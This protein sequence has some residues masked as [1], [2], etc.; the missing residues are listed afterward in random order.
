MITLAQSALAKRKAGGSGMSPG[1]GHGGSRGHSG[2]SDGE[3]KACDSARGVNTGM[4]LLT[5]RAV[6]AS[7]SQDE[8][9]TGVQQ[10]NS[11]GNSDS[12]RCCVLG[13]EGG[14]G[15]SDVGWGLDCGEYHR[16]S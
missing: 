8:G 12:H 7:S 14:F 2:R 15:L 11:F 3:G 10:Q 5:P 6:P 13:I 16:I 4:G 1:E 9:G